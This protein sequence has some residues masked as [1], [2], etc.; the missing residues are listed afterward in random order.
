MARRESK[1]HSRVPIAFDTCELQSNIRS[2]SELAST[3]SLGI[4]S[5]REDLDTA[6][7]QDAR[8]RATDEPFS[9]RGKREGRRH[10]L[11][12][13]RNDFQKEEGALGRL[14]RLT[15]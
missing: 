3:T 11:V 5:L 4:D 2:F 7:L 13:R 12:A 8:L 10:N 9:V 15:T 1:T 14:T 6:L